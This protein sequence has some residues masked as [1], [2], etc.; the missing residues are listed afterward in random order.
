M[1]LGLSAPLHRTGRWLG[2]TDDGTVAAFEGRRAPRLLPPALIVSATALGVIAALAY[3]WIIPPTY[4]A[5]AEVLIEAETDGA[6]DDQLIETQAAIIRSELILDPLIMLEDLGADPTFVDRSGETILQSILRGSRGGNRDESGQAERTEYETVLR[7]LRDRISVRRKGT[8]NVLEIAVRGPDPDRAAVLANTLVELY[9]DELDAKADVETSGRP[10]TGRWIMFANGVQDLATLKRAAEEAARAV[11]EFRVASGVVDDSDVVA[12]NAML[13][14]ATARLSDGR[15]RLDRLERERRA[16]S[17]AG[18]TGNTDALDSPILID[19]RLQQA[20]IA[21]EFAEI[22]DTLMPGHPT[23]QAI[24]DE[25][26]AINT[27]IVDEIGRL[28]ARLDFEIGAAKQAVERLEAEVKAA[29]ADRDATAAVRAK[30]A[31]LEDEA[32]A[33]RGLYESVAAA[34][35]Q[36]EADGRSGLGRLLFPDPSEEGGEETGS[37]PD[38]VAEDPADDAEPPLDTAATDAESEDTARDAGE[39]AGEAVAVSEPDPM[40]AEDSQATQAI[41]AET[42]LDDGSTPL[43]SP[44]PEGLVVAEGDTAPAESAGEMTASDTAP[45]QEVAD[46]GEPPLPSDEAATADDT[47]TTAPDPDTATERDPPMARLIT[48]ARPPTRPVS[49]DPVVALATGTGAG[50]ITGLFLVLLAS[51]AG[52]AGE[53]DYFI[54]DETERFHG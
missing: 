9:F 6:A 35:A 21:A 18:K 29:R 51:A 22:A 14:E 30:L 45:P 17:K 50:F 52:R 40:P 28:A 31:D 37:P 43:P 19:L 11:S 13:R 42:A 23:R 15:L 27:A 53:D 41:V 44:R 20:Q 8:T 47:A 16:A 33:A 32:A 36:E 24:E 26:A 39:D 54:V 3:L 2:V 1:A 10:Q 4:E 34:T 25:R 48:A 38:A 46:A 5:V 7:L 12:A 49:P